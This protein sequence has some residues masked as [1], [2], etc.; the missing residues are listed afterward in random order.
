MNR[1]VLLKRIAK[2]INATRYLEIGVQRGHTFSKM[3]FPVKVGVDPDK[4]SAA[5][6]HMGSD[7][8]FATLDPDTKFDLIFIDGLHHA[9]QV[10]RDVENAL[11]HL[12]EG[13]VIVCHDCDPPTKISGMR[14]Q[15]AGVW[16]GDVWK[17]WL[18]L[19]TKLDAEMYVVDTDLGCGVIVPSNETNRTDKSIPETWEAFQDDKHFWLKLVKIE[20]FERRWPVSAQPAY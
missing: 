16:C 18:E 11:K 5:T 4:R 12:S 6:V 20:A 2:S 13:G 8:Y 9:D 14:Q 7:N 1:A 10:V 15:C 19:R 3:D 17:A